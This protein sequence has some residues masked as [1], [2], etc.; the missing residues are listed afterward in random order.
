MCPSCPKNELQS[1]EIQI[2]LS[3]LIKI[4]QYPSSSSMI[5]KYNLT[6]YLILDSLTQSINYNV[7]IL[8]PTIKINCDENPDLNNNQR[9]KMD[10]LDKIKQNRRRLFCFAL[11]KT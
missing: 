4:A 9:I 2:K 1:A 10:I 5:E 6:D 8:I 3:F 7:K 11:M